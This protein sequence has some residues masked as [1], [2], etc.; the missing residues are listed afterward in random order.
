MDE[1]DRYLQQHISKEHIFF[2]SYNFHEP[3]LAVEESYADSVDRH[4][5]WKILMNAMS[6]QRDLTTKTVHCDC[7]AIWLKMASLFT[8]VSHIQRQ[9]AIIAF[10]CIFMCPKET[11]AMYCRR[12]EDGLDKQQC[13][14]LDPTAEAF[15]HAS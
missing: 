8:V 15:L 2:S 1:A 14:G 13:T 12:W 5:T 6:N 3:Y 4:T 9:L 11:F 10:D 7:R